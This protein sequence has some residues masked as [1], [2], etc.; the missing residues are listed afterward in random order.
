MGWLSPDESEEQ[1]EQSLITQSVEIKT[2]RS[3]AELK[4]KAEKSRTGQK[5]NRPEESGPDLSRT[6]EIGTDTKDEL[7]H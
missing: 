7:E 4:N 6:K 5:K 3:R 1:R 2:E